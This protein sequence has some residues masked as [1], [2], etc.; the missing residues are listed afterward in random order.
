MLPDSA[1]ARA[2]EVQSET[3][4]IRSMRARVISF[5]RR[6]LAYCLY[7]SGL[8]NI[9]RF[10]A[11]S[12]ELRTTPDSSLRGLRRS[13][14]PKFGIL[15]YHRVGTEGVPLYSRLAPKVF[16]AQ[17]H[18][19]RKH[20]RIVPLGTLCTELRE[21]HQVEPTLAVT[22]DDGYRDLYNYAYPVLRK[23]EIPATI[24]LI[25]QCMLTGEA[26][27]YDRIHVAL[28]RAPGPVLE[29]ELNAPR[30]FVLRDAAARAAAAW[31]IICY[32]RS[33]P[34]SQRRK[35][36]GS[37][38]RATCFPDG[39][40]QDRMLNWDQVRAMQEHA[41]SFGAHTMTHPAVSRLDP[42]VFTEELFESRRLL[43][44]KLETS[45]QDFAYPFGKPNDCSWTAEKFLRSHDYRSAVTTVEG[46]NGRGANLFWLNRLQIGESPSL[47]EFASRIGMAFLSGMPETATPS[48]PGQE[49]PARRISLGDNVP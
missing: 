1:P 37:F 17:M 18:Y 12:H 4:Q 35:W 42:A 39:E 32:L 20:Y 40:L 26:P 19:L 6:A 7:H 16:E 44:S 22:F 10:L 45:V 34:D 21:G 2:H 38:E 49:S 43:E 11:Q 25:G 36:C 48:G 14:S 15:C 3:S 31:E 41:I 13:S 46:I 23:Y 28:V 9:L 30:Q 47:P 24:Y 33:V 29:V 5:C 8:M 27:W